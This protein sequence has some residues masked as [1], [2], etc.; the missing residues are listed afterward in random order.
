MAR[1]QREK[2]LAEEILVGLHLI[3]EV[4]R[5]RVEGRHK[6]VEHLHGKRVGSRGEDA[7]QCTRGV[8]ADQQ[9][10]GREIL[11]H[12]RNV[13]SRQLG[14]VHGVGVSPELGLIL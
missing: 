9:R 5:N 1:V 11:D 12:L 2:G 4:F 6:A 13:V 8:D 7:R 10:R 3:H 14:C